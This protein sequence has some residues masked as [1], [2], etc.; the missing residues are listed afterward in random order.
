MQKKFT[1]TGMTCSAC[2]AN[3]E[4]A[5]RKIEGVERA[6]VNLLNNSLTLIYDENIVAEDKIIDAIKNIGYG[7]C[8]MV[9]RKGQTK[10]PPTKFRLKQIYIFAIF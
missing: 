2:S 1:V 7:V 9:N 10:P 5:V 8:H 3:V 4:K 6:D